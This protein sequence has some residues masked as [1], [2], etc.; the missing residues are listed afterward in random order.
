MG[1][2]P[3]YA[4]SPQASYA[5]KYRMLVYG[6]PIVPIA[7]PNQDVLLKI[8]RKNVPRSSF[9]N[10]FQMVLDQIRPFPIFPD[11]IASTLVE[12]CM[13]LSYKILFLR[14]VLKGLRGMPIIPPQ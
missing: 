3:S 10:V 4:N 2:T 14:W 12:F 6:E 7:T 9:F 11:T 5:S 1:T 8:V 13:V